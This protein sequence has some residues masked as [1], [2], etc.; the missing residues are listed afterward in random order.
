MLRRLPPIGL[1]AAMASLLERRMY[2]PCVDY[3]N[4]RPTTQMRSRK[5]GGRGH[6][7][8]CS[9][10]EDD[11]KGNLCRTCGVEEANMLRYPGGCGVSLGTLR[12]EPHR[13]N[14]GGEHGGVLQQFVGFWRTLFQ[15]RFGERTLEGRRRIQSCCGWDMCPE[16]LC[17]QRLGM[18]GA[19][20]SRE[21]EGKIS[22]W[23]VCV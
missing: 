21:E 7:W 20:Q 5:L 8:D 12:A 1:P 3:P 6:P 16:H 13:R 15:K 22:P 17:A 2:L 23:C 18:H 11:T 4:G 10:K 14:W 9:P 19:L